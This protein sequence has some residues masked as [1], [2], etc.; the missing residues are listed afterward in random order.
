MIS[1][2]TRLRR[3]A[4]VA[5]LLS[6]LL[7]LGEPLQA[8]PP[9]P[10]GTENRVTVHYHRQDDRYSDVGLWSWDGYEKNTPAQNELA[11][12]GRDDFGAIFQFDRANYGGS[13]KIGLIPRLGHNWSHKDG[14]DKFWT[15]V[16][17][18][19]VWLIN[20][21]DNVFT[22]RPDVTPHVEVA[23]LDSASAVTLRLS[24]PAPAS[25][26]V[27]ILDEKNVAHAVES[28]YQV[29]RTTATTDSNASATAPYKMIVVPKEPLDVTS[30]G[31]RVQVEG[32]GPAVALTPRGI[33]QNRELFYDGDARLGAD[34]TPQGTTFRI[35][36]P[37][38]TA[39]SLLLYDEASGPTGRT[40]QALKPQPKGL[41]EL[42][43][44]DDLRGKFYV[45][46]FEAPDL[47]PTHEVLDPYA[48]NAVASSTRGRITELPEPSPHGPPVASPTDMVIYEMHVR[49]FTISPTSGVK[50]RGLYLGF[51]EA[52]THLADDAS[53]R[54]ALDHLTE[55]GVTH[56]ELLPVQD[57][58][59]NE[60]DPKFNWGYIPEAYFSPEGMYA[61]DADD[62]SRVHELK[63][64]VDALHARG[65]GVLMDVVYNHTALDASL[66]SVVPGYY[67]RHNANGS[68]ADGSACGNEFRSEA[69]MA[70]KLILD[71]LKFWTRQY[72][73]DGYRFDL[74]AL[75]D[76]ETMQQAERE[77]RGINPS[78]VLYGEPWTGGNSPLIDKTDKTA[79]HKVPV[80]AFNDDYRN[81]LKGSPDGHDPGFIQNG[82]NR[83]ALKTAMTLSH[84][85]ASPGQSINYMTC[86]DNLVL[87]DK[88]KASM[89]GADDPMLFETM[90]LA[91]LT[92][93]TSQ[94]VP[95]FQ[96][97]EEFA[98]TKGGNNNSYDAPDSVNEVDWTLKRKHFD[99]FAY[100]RDVIALRKSHPV[101]RLRTREE[102]AARLK[103]E[104]T[105]D[106][107]TLMY[108]LD[109]AGVPGEAW[110][111]V[112]VVLNSDGRVLMPRSR[113]RTASGRSRSTS[114]ARRRTVPFPVRSACVRNQGWYFFNVSRQPRI[115]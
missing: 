97:G 62:D 46:S 41:W 4:F 74:M 76:Q 110:K 61:T 112:C 37:T 82:S 56:V 39:V 22:K 32:F 75:I 23:F 36:A 33:L 24:E 68:L 79:F 67:Y 52:G 3:C 80:G 43:V 2:R 28:A 70:R 106:D 93:F 20:N 109:G 83:E 58:E 66:E 31:Y 78:I 88:L 42:T 86:H 111:R 53:I 13:D 50:D 64:L 12:T 18:G 45:Y 71:S 96:G 65:I 115:F 99:L 51:T 11:P 1:T 72:G 57:F 100:T 87:W 98:R 19:E 101:F 35:F 7:S 21:R 63:A 40:V 102:I 104:N 108:T 8:T 25:P 16:L 44:K 34:Y 54:T 5:C 47:D 114:R 89:P 27:T 10:T 73:I 69:P 94:G 91:Y 48:V 113:C 9:A 77:L 17:G 103:F 49:D 90:K 55:L 29:G 59:N 105:P 38:A 81:A 6:G 30:P 95:F 14:H 26:K 60:A 84:W 92:L 15:P 85:L 107:K